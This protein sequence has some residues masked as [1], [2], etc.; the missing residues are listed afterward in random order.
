MQ[1]AFPVLGM[2]A[3][4]V[5]SGTFT[6]QGL[7][8]LSS[9]VPEDSLGELEEKDHSA[10]NPALDVIQMAVKNVKLD[11]LCPKENA[12][13]VKKS[14]RNVS[15]IMTLTP[16]SV[17]NATTNFCWKEEPVR[18]VLTRTARLARMPNIV[19][20]AKKDLCR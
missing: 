8:S 9:L 2:F 6:F 19:M 12:N 11:L 1:L 13:D 17:L 16:Q 18:T 4:A 5:V 15:L 7:A 14:A 3:W 10:R 20:F